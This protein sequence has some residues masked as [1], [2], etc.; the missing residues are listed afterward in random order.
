MAMLPLEPVVDPRGNSPP[1]SCRDWVESRL[2]FRDPTPDNTDTPPT[3]TS[4]PL[5]SDS[6]SDT[7]IN[8]SMLKPLR[9]LTSK[10][11][12]SK[13]KP[14]P[15]FDES[16]SHS[17]IVA[18]VPPPTGDQTQIIQYYC[19]NL[20]LF[21]ECPPRHHCHCQATPSVTRAVTVTCRITPGGRPHPTSWSWPPCTTI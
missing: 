17:T 12:T 9:C 15:T 16:Q 21:Q 10:S 14:L 4:L 20:S 11:K 2:G 3:N 5:L 18:A 8:G 7:N 6:T 13:L 1:E 19:L